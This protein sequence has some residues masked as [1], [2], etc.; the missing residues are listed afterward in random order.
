MNDRRGRA[1]IS[2]ECLIYVSPL[3]SHMCVCAREI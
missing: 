3:A 1:L 2:L